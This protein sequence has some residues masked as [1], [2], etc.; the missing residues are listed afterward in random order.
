MNPTV[1]GI[2]LASLSLEQLYHIRDLVSAEIARR[3]AP[4]PDVPGPMFYQGDAND[5]PAE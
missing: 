2:P 4:P 3:Q 1:N 5:P